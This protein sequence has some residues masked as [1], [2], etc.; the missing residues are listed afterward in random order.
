MRS[1][2]IVAVGAAALAF[3]AV[4]V[5]G[6]AAL[7]D[8]QVGSMMLL[9]VGSII[10]G[11]LLLLTAGILLFDVLREQL[12]QLDAKVDGIAQRL[13]KALEDVEERGFSEGMISGIRSRTN[14]G[15]VRELSPRNTR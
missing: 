10:A 12:R 9:V 11:S 4:V 3:A 2:Y 15:V 14:S 8:A 6:G 13:D 1:P 7:F 5:D